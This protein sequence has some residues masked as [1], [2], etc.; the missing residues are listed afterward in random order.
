MIHDAVTSVL[1][2]EDDAD[3][4]H[5]LRVLLLR[6]GYRVTEASAGREGLRQFHRTR[7]DLVVLD[8]GLPDLDG[9][10]VLERLRDLSDTPVLM[11][12]AR[13]AEGD[14]VRGLNGGADDYLT[15][16]FSPA[17]LSARLLAIR[18]R[19]ATVAGGTVY[20]DGRV[21]LDLSLSQLT[22]HGELVTLTPTEFRLLSAL[23]EHAGQVLSAEQLA[24]LAWTAAAGRD[25]VKY[26]VLRLR[27]KLGSDEDGLS[28]IETVRGFG[29]RYRPRRASA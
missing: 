27:R 21:R 2:I 9:W 22:V 24:D 12:S 5:L 23:V 3:L 25:P 15:K 4:R 10:Q 20:D 13:S 29:Y 11:L 17:E 19:T 18:R 28:P 8:V 1:V 16:P 14:K 7:P 26:A 6:E